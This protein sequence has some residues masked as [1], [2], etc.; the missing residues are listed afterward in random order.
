M[1]LQQDE[2][3]RPTFSLRQL[4]GVVWILS[5][6]FAAFPMGLSVAV[7][8]GVPFGVLGTVLSSSCCYFC[9]PIR[10]SSV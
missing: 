4:F 7:L 1:G 10:F 3:K 6:V 9:C 8:F 5:V 2:L